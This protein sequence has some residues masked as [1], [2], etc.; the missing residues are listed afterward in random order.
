MF[1][2]MHQL[3]RTVVIKQP[4]R[5]EIYCL[6][7][8]EARSLKSKVTQDHAIRRFQGRTPSCL[9]IVLVG[10]RNPWYSLMCRNQCSVCW[11]SHMPFSPHVFCPNS[12]YLIRILD[13]K[14][15]FLLKVINLE[16]TS[17]TEHGSCF[18][19]HFT[20]SFFISNLSTIQTLQFIIMFIFIDV[21]YNLKNHVFSSFL[22]YSVPISKQF[23]K[24]L[25]SSECNVAFLQ[26]QGRISYQ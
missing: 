9:S 8:L 25:L 11:Y 4:N 6:T 18:L 10:T 2:L 22:H 12:L 13:E 21:S 15:T 19:S 24:S 3:P 14:A 23:S 7:I 26:I 5:M 1:H 20:V 16:K 17:K